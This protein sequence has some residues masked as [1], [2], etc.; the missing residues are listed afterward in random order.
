MNL[1]RLITGLFLLIIGII[2]IILAISTAWWFVFYGII[3]FVLGLLI[4][5]NKHEDKI[6]KR[7]DLKEKRYR[8]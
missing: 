2:F 6:E 4:L 5:F 8:K 3:L 1:G 7:K